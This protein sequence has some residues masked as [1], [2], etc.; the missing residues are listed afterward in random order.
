MTLAGVTL[1]RC[2]RPRVAVSI[3]GTLVP[4][5]PLV[6]GA[7]GI[8]I[9]IPKNIAAASDGQA[10][11]TVAIYGKCKEDPVLA[12]GI[13]T[14]RP[15]H[16]AG[17]GAVVPAPIPETKAATLGTAVVMAQ[18]DVIT[19]T[20]NI[21][22]TLS[23][24][25]PP[26]AASATTALVSVTVGGIAAELVSISEDRTKLVA[27]ISPSNPVGPRGTSVPVRVT[28]TSSVAYE[29]TTT[30]VSPVISSL[31]KAVAGIPLTITG[32]GFT[33]KSVVFTSNDIQLPVNFISS[34]RL[35]TTHGLAERIVAMGPINIIVRNGEFAN[36]L[37]VP[38]R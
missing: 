29:G 26:T 10:I 25:L 35:T 18:K 21:I 16:V 12:S 5:V 17:V 36:S 14:V 27:I 2:R 37:E 24:P 31:S 38:L 4:L 23:S 7:T 13:F 20:G 3:S 22:I 15:A 32:S 19:P 9:E 11:V 6:K 34:S 30:V 8:L 28:S 1:P 33:L